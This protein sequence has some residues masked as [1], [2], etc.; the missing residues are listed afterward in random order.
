LTAFRQAGHVC[1]NGTPQAVQKANP[2]R[3]KTPHRHF[4]KGGSRRMKYSMMPIALGMKIASSV[5]IT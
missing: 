3:T 4:L 5:H 1:V 2:L